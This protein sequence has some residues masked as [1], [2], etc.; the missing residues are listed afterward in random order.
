MKVDY[1]NFI[2]HVKNNL[3]PD[4]YPQE[5]CGIGKKHWTADMWTIGVSECMIVGE[6][7]YNPQERIYKIYKNNIIVAS[8]LKKSMIEK[9]N[10]VKDSTDYL[11]VAEVGRGL[12]I[13]IANN[14]K[15]WKKI[16]CYDHVDYNRYLKNYFVNEDIRFTASPTTVFDTTQLKEKCIM[17]LNTNIKHEINALIKKMGKP[18][19]RFINSDKILH[20]ILNGEI[21]K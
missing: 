13:L 17:L 5:K 8:N 21:I 18:I 19:Q 1:R 15:K 9:L 6:E 14:I 10:K 11:L 2:K 20:I 7:N 12:D 4:D 16:Y 3:L